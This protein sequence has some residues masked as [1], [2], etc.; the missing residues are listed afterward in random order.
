MLFRITFV[1]GNDMRISSVQLVTTVLGNNVDST[2]TAHAA[3][4]QLTLLVSSACNVCV[5]ASIAVA[6]FY[7]MALAV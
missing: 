1:L 5:S 2:N 3:W 7:S 4:V 6:E